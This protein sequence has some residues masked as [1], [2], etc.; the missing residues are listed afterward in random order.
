[1]NI[2]GQDWRNASEL[3]KYPFTDDSELLST[4]GL[5]LPL[6]F[7]LDISIYA[8]GM[9]QPVWLSGIASENNLPVLTFTDGITSISG[10]DRLYTASGVESGRV[11]FGASSSLVTGTA[12]F[13]PTAAQLCVGCVMPLSGEFLKAVVVE[14]TS[15]SNVV[16]LAAEQGVKLSINSDSSIRVDAI[17]ERSTYLESER[18]NPILGIRLVV[19]GVEIGVAHPTADGRIFIRDDNSLSPDTILRLVPSDN[20]FVITILGGNQTSGSEA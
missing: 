7:I 4:T 12:S 6:D 5:R 2:S 16:H 8:R 10:H 20:G 3:S 13:S 18:T 15:F 14:G 11:V 9:N 17:G 1:M 19:A